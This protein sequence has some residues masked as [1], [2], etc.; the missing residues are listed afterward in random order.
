MLD[1]TLGFNWFVV[2]NY[3][4]RREA[5]KPW[6]LVRLIWRVWRYLKEF[7]ASSLTGFFTGSRTY[8]LNKNTLYISKA[9]KKYLSP[10][11]LYRRINKYCL[12]Q[13][14]NRKP[15]P[16]AIQELGSIDADLATMQEWIW[17]TILRRSW[18][19]SFINY[20]CEIVGVMDNF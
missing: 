12:I 7:Y 20:I 3:K 8:P 18:R 6:D 16:S 15:C 5:F 10:W 9:S 4:T 2:D 1:L 14:V 11:L 17:L 13:S 19:Y